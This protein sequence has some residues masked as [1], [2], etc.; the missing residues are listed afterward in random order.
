[1]LLCR[2]SGGVWDGFW[3][4]PGGGVEFGEHPE[5]AVVREV[6]EETGFHVVVGA[7]KRVDHHLSDFDHGQVHHVQF[8]YEVEIVGGE[9]TCE[10]EG[11]T[12]LVGWFTAQEASSL[13]KVPLAEAGLSLLFGA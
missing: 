8:I 3:T 6:F 9:L 2:L 10:S 13:K 5:G 7:L 1:M 12:D 11:T 4:L